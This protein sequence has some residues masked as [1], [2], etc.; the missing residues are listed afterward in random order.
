[1]MNTKEYQNQILD[2]LR[3]IFGPENVEKE[4]DSLKYDSHSSNHK[5]IYGPRLDIAVGP[6]N[7]MVE[8]DTQ[9]DNTEIMKNHPLTRRIVEEI[10][11]DDADFDKC[12]N[13]FSRCYLAIEIELG[14]N[15]KSSNSLKHILGSIINATVSGSIGIVITD[16]NTEEKVRRLYSYLGRLRYYGRLE[17]NTIDNLIIIDKDIFMDI[18][19][20]IK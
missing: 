3:D 8:M 20:E 14:R 11:W 13:G 4:W 18:L 1:M 15:N 19:S 10:A 7:G 5:G 2:I 16:S 12:W 17:V 9:L 6:F